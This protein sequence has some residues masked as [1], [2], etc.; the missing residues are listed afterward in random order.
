MNKKPKMKWEIRK[1]K[2]KR[3]VIKICCTYKKSYLIKKNCFKE[4]SSSRCIDR[5]EHIELKGFANQIDAAE[6]A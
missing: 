5:G 4:L 6:V 2:Q 1:R 3:T